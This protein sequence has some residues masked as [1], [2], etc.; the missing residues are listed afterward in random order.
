MPSDL[1][2][3]KLPASIEPRDSVENRLLAE[4]GSVFVAQ[5]VLP[6]TKIVFEDE[7]DVTY[8]QSNLEA[9]SETLGSFPIELQAKAMDDLLSAVSEAR[10][11]GKDIRPRFAD[12]AR[13]NYKDTVGL[14]R[15]RVEP[16]LEHW[17]ALGRISGEEVIKIKGLSPYDQVAVVLKLEED[18]I[19]FAKDLSKSI[20]YSVA[21]PGASQHLSM[22]ALD[23]AEFDDPQICDILARNKWFQTVV[24]DLPHFTYL[25]IEEPNLP[26]YGLK[27]VTTGQRRFW[28]PDLDF[29]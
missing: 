11:A 20:L 4:Y 28:L 15:S 17:S 21:P 26:G 19:Y 5:N 6:P 27:L 3:S 1:F 16:A 22:L 23:V 9:S 24:S 7:A 8:F 10:E 25:G 18:G 2:L 13:R 29:N 14:W 12:S